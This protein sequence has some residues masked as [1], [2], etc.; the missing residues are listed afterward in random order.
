MKEQILVEKIRVT[1]TASDKN[2]KHGYLQPHKQFPLM[3]RTPSG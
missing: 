1:E 2:D 3:E